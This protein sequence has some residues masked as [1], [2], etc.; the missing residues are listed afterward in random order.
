MPGPE[1]LPDRLRG[2]LGVIHLLFSAGHTAL[3]GASLMRTDLADQALLLAR[4]LRELMPD[5][6]EVWGLL[7]LLLVTDA[8]RSTRVDA[9]GRLL[10]LE[11]QDRSRWDQAMI[12]EAHTL[13]VDGLRGGRPGRY[14]LQ[15]AIA[16]LYAQAPSYD[17]TDW[18]QIVT[19]YDALLAV[20]PSPVVALN[21]TVAVARVSGAEQA[22]KEV[23]ALE[24]DG[25]LAGY[26]YLPAIKAD[27]LQ[28][29][30]RT[31]EA[32]T[33]Y[34]E[35]LSLTTNEAERDFLAGRLTG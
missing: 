23:E 5:E 27:L 4:M 32:A 31:A 13:I 33:A 26:Q 6:R 20:W 30:G 21:R 12:T 9:A 16:S 19:L 17:E 7:A 28:S 1:E 3:S 34:R 2:V 18:P 10:R 22:L 29:L 25:R 11:D 35:A 24:H 8:R 15:A 14:V